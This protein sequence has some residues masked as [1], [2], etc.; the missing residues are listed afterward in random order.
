MAITSELKLNIV[1]LS[2]YLV[3]DTLPEQKN[4]D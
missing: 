1:L 4:I 2:E 3:S